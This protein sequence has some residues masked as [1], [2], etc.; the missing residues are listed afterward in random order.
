MCNT[1]RHHTRRAIHGVG[2]C[3]SLFPLGRTVPR[4]LPCHF[5]CD[6][7]LS[8][9]ALP[10]LPTCLVCRDLGDKLSRKRP[11]KVVGSTASCL[12][13]WRTDNQAATFGE[14]LMDMVVE[15]LRVVTSWPIKTNGPNAGRAC[16]RLP[17]HCSIFRLGFGQVTLA[18]HNND[19]RTPWPEMRTR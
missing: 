16:R 14:G 5:S 3:V 12:R 9:N 2:G 15:L 18:R 10:A 6:R 1:P 7:L 11:G 19:T 17:S 8:K 4:P 13:P